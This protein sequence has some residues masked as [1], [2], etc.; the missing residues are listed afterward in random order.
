MSSS[1]RE[2]MEFP[3]L[4]VMIF[5]D[6][7]LTFKQLEGER[8]DKSWAR[9]NEL[10][11]Q[12]PTHDILDIILLDCFY[13]SLG[14]GKKRL[15]DQFIPG[16]I[17]KQ[18]YVI[19]AQVLNQMAKT[20]QVVEK[21]FMLASLMTHMDELAQKMMKIEVQCKRKDKYIPPHER[22]S[23]KENEVKHLEGILSII[24]HKVTEQDRELEEMKE[25]IQWMKPMIWS[26]SRAV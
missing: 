24:L 4:E 17:A 13:R 2:L 8:I 11:T 7:I 22:R 12:C 1:T 3:P 9:L 16:G 19:A 14:P 20:K 23:P 15:V 6:R 25:N 21:D 18:P 10:I 26:H 5:C